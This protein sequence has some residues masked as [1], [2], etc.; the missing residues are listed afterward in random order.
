MIEKAK[1]L[2]TIDIDWDMQEE[3]YRRGKYMELFEKLW[4]AYINKTI[5]H[6][7]PWI[8]TRVNSNYWTQAQAFAETV[9]QF[10]GNDILDNIIQ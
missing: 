2:V 1:K 3:W 9:I 4:L 5:P 6:V 7:T 10:Q 8:D